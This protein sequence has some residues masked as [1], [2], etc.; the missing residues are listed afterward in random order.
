V[1]KKVILLAL[2]SCSTLA[3]EHQINLG[4]GYASLKGT[5]DD[6]IG[7]AANINYAYQFHPNL[8]LELGRMESEGLLTSLFSGT[9]ES[10]DYNTTYLGVKAH[11]Y[12]VSFLNIYALGGANYSEVEKSSKVKSTGITT[13]S[14]DDGINAY[15][16]AGAELLFANHF[17]LGLEYR[18]FLLS[19]DYKS[20]AVLANVSFKF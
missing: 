6:D 7:F 16:G 11:Y 3:A 2:F 9:E 17:G 12:P 14:S 10:I 1:F 19:E 5:S 4:L 13:K 8:S 15:F 18:T 20:N